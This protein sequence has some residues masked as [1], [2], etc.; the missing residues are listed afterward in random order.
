MVPACNKGVLLHEVPKGTSYFLNFCFLMFVAE[1]IDFDAY[2]GTA[3]HGFLIAANS[4]N[5]LHTYATSN[6]S[7][8]SF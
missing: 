2:M 3:V 7:I 6:N 4:S 5:C 8:I 1:H